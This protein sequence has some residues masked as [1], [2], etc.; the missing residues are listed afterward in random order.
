[1]NLHGPVRVADVVSSGTATITL[2][3]DAWKEV[4][5]GAT[6]HSVSV[7]P[8]KPGPKV[9]PV[10]PNL[11]ATLVHPEKKADTGSQ[12]EFTK[13]GNRLFVSGYPSGVVQIWDV[14]SRK[15]L[16]RFETPP[17][18]R[19]TSQYAILAP[20]WKTLYV[21]V[22][23]RAVRTIERDG[24]KSYRFDYSG[25]IRVWDILSGKE[26]ESLKPPAG[27]AP[28]YGRITPDSR[29]ILCAEQPSYDVSDI[30]PCVTILWDLHTG[31]R[32][33]F[34]DGIVLP[35]FTPDGKSA[36][37]ERFER[38]VKSATW[39]SEVRI[40]DLPS[41]KVTAKVSCPRNDV[42]FSVWAISPDGHVMAVYVGDITGAAK[43]FGFFDIKTLE[44][45]GKLVGPSASPK[46]GMTSGV[47]TSDGKRFIAID[48]TANALVWDIAEQKLIRK[49]HLGRDDAPWSFAISPDGGTLAFSWM[50][51]RDPSL[52]K[53]LMP[54]PQDLP[55]PRISLID[56]AGNAP[57]RILIAPHGYRGDV[58]FSPD[59]KTLAFG[60]S[61]AVHLFDL[62]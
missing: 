51:K 26:K 58:A 15:E 38:D 1:V 49:V 7:L 28:L 29:F 11:V 4:R 23:R 60:S 62:R 40:V 59:G 46:S 56:L 5:V 54:D 41:G 16:R 47:F 42:A 8:P 44:P 45:R 10:A 24:K 21:P 19:G 36:L 25:E 37:T 27:W 17:G 35:K 33:K 30:P 6:T 3:F 39:S 13:D 32:T 12:L 9:E 48:E 53:V 14:A 18:Y 43:E 57:P 52:A 34:F 2:S 31:R 20:D 50:P 55:Q 61:G 22:E